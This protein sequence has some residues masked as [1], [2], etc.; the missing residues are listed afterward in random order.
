M[1]GSNNGNSDGVIR[2]EQ[3]EEVDLEKFA[4]GHWVSGF[5]DGEGHFGLSI[6]HEHPNRIRPSA[7]F[8]IGLRDDD[9]DIL[10]SIMLFFGCGAIYPQRAHGN[11][12]PGACYKVY[13]PS[14]LWN[15]IIPHF[16]KFPLRAKKGNELRCWKMGVQLLTHVSA[17]KVQGLGGNMGTAPKW[18][19]EE[20]AN[21]E[22]LATT[23]SNIR[24]Y[25]S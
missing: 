6:K 21:F 10:K 19:K 25:I 23:L 8:S 7:V 17:R 1:A 4:F 13:K 24:R 14:E 3:V 20:L 5:T 22:F 12:N 16:D 11:A 2:I 15:I 9:I 18:G